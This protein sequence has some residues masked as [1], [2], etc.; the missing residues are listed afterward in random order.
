MDD[1]NPQSRGGKK[2]AQNLTPYART[3]IARSGAMARWH[4]PFVQP[5]AKIPKALAT[6]VL[7]LGGIPCAVLD[8]ENNTQLL[9]QAGFL[10]ALGRTKTPKSAGNS[11]IAH[12]PA[13][14]R[15]RNLELFISKELA[16]S[17][18]PIVFETE[19]RG[20]AG[21]TLAL[22]Y[23]AQL[24]PGV[25]WA[26]HEAQIAGK[27]LPSQIH[28]AEACTRLLKGLTDVA[29]DALIDEA[30]GFQDV[31]AKNALIKLLEKYISKDAL[32]WV[33]TFDDDFYKEMLRLHGYAYDSNS[34]KRPMSFARRT[35]DIYKRLAPGI[36]DELGRLVRRGSS[37]RP[38]EKL[39]Q[40]LSK[41]EG[42][43]KLLEM[44]TGVKVIMKLSADLHDYEKKLDRVYPRFGDTIQIPFDD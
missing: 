37:G 5:G 33:K 32:P 4:M 22:G 38:N 19:R 39:F 18:T 20:G 21:G 10:A 17:S 16:A 12:L 2:R 35:E 28:I 30:T 41:H 26:Y 6:G 36:R 8:D 7:A 1:S 23:R 11:N 44:L 3:E 43:R 34:V 13:F 15:A 31:R 25:C 40:Y 24:L 9:T 14:L 29:I 27:L 42:Y